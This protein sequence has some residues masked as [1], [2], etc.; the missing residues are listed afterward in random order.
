MI[1]N[2][3]KIRTMLSFN[4]KNDFYFVQI[5]KRRKDNPSM[6]R[7]MMVIDSFYIDSLDNYDKKVP[8][9]IELCNIENARAYFRL[10]KRNYKH[11]APHMAKRV[12]DIAFTDD[13]KA[14]RTTFDSIAGEFHSDTDKK[15]LID[16][17]DDK[18]VKYNE[19]I[20]VVAGF[21]RDAGREPMTELLLSKNGAHLITHPFNL[22]KFK[23]LFLVDVHKDANTILYCP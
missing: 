22:I 11:L 8:H 19:L 10:N 5:L 12:V 16:I 23:V 14:L 7:D 20:D 1:N 9:I 13:C 18:N 3:E 4:D 6:E 17:D 15:W 21:Q 2:S